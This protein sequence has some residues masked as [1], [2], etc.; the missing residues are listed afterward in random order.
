MVEQKD[1]A[2]G[3]SQLPNDDRL[4][5]LKTES[6]GKSAAL[7]TGLER[8]REDLVFFTD[9]DCTVENDWLENG[10]LLLE[11]EPAVGAIFSPLLAA[12]HSPGYEWVPT[13]EPTR[14]ETLSG[15]YAFLRHKGAG[16]NLVVR[17]TVLRDVGGFD[18]ELGPGAKFKGL[19]EFDYF[20]RMLGRGVQVMYDTTNPVL[21]WGIRSHSDGSAPEL[22][23]GYRLGQGAVLAKHLKCGNMGTLVMLGRETWSASYWLVRTTLTSGRPRGLRPWAELVRGFALG[24]RHPVDHERRVF[25]PVSTHRSSIPS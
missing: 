24:L 19:E 25:R 3:W 11:Q 21:H 2:A 22:L 17:R 4:V 13:F 9:D 6:R 7:N 14:Q 16:A 18:E 5:H 20:Y 1:P 23:R 10:A 8:I 12:P 15:R